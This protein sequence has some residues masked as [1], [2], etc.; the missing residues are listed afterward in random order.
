MSKVQHARA[1]RASRSAE[2]P[3]QSLLDA[4]EDYMILCGGDPLGEVRRDRIEPTG[5]SD[6]AAVPF[7]PARRKGPPGALVFET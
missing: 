7:Q 4:L 6:R 5:A 2:N 3:E 1:I